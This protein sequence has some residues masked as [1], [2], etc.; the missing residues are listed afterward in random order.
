MGHPRIKDSSS[1]RMFKTSDPA[2]GLPPPTAPSLGSD[3][4]DRGL[5]DENEGMYPGWDMQDRI[6]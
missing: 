4:E 3:R 2:R 6:Q 5:W 1:V